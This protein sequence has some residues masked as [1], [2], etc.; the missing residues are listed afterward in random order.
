MFCGIR[1]LIA[2]KVWPKDPAALAEAKKEAQGLTEAGSIGQLL[3][4]MSWRNAESEA[5]KKLKTRIVF[6]GDNI[7][8]A[9]GEYA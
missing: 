8:T 6:R 2:R 3:T 9:D 1:E 7:R 5:L 4:I